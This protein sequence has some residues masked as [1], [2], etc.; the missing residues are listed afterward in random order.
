[1][2]ME[3]SPSKK[4]RVMIADDIQETRRNIRLMLSMNPGV[5]VV[6]IASNGEQ[7]VEMA[8]EQ[9]PD[10][11]VMDI[12]M[13]GMDGLAAYEEITKFAPDTGC[14]VVSGEKHIAALGVAMQIGV[15]EY[16][17]KPFT[18][19]ELNNAVNRVGQ[20]VE[21]RRRES[22]GTAV[23]VRQP[24][25]PRNRKPEAQAIEY[26]K[27]GRTDHET[28]EVFEKLAED[29]DCEL[30]WLKY[31]AALYIERQEWGKLKA[32]AERLEQK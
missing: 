30:R 6:A 8:R 25:M 5:V 19:D 29:P 27:L 7:A 17:V 9:K 11:V 28:L 22:P 24:E 10:V 18:V 16:L 13:P 21:S 15:Q 2:Q 32:L 1:M 3:T 12:N 31:L 4:L 20:A 14:V 26:I 23:K